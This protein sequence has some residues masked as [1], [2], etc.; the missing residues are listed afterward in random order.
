[1]RK[2]EDD[3][4]KYNDLKTDLLN[5][6]KCIDCCEEDEKC[7]YQDLAITYSIRLKNFQHFI[8]REYGLKCCCSPKA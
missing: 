7:F 8:E 5:I 1:M 2:I 6:G 4:I 3:I